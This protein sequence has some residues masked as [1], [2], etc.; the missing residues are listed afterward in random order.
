MNDP[1]LIL[2]V[3][4]D[5]DDAAIHAAYLALVRDCPPERDPQRFQQLRAALEKIR[6]HRDRVA[7]EMY[8]TT[9]PDIDDILARAAPTEAGKRPSMALM[10]ALL[11]GE[12]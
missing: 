11:R 7:L 5:A 10:A 8:D 12:A 1:Y 6:T 4:D 9:P 2:G 3:A